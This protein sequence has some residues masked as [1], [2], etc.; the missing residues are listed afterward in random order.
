MANKIE[1][2]KS[3]I[4]QLSEKKYLFSKAFEYLSE[5]ILIIENNE[6]IVIINSAFFKLL[7]IEEK[8]SIMKLS[9]LKRHKILGD[10][11]RETEASD[12]IHYAREIEMFDPEKKV[13]AIKSLL[14]K[15][16][17]LNEYRIFILQDVTLLR[18]LRNEPFEKRYRKAM[19]SLGAGLAHEIGNPLNAMNIHIQLIKMM[20][21]KNIFNEDDI[22]NLKNEV[23]ILEEEIKRIDGVIS[24]FLQAV[25]PGKIMYKEVDIIDVIK[26]SVESFILVANKKNIKIDF[27]F[28]FERKFIFADGEKISQAI[29]NI[30]KNAIEAICSNG[31]IRISCYEK[32]GYIYIE[33]MD[34]GPGI[35][36]EKISSIFNPFFTTKTNGMGL[37]LVIAHQAVKE[38]DGEI[39]VKSSPGKGTT[40]ILEI[41]LREFKLK[42]IESKI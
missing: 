17:F 25:R 35:D 24:R 22:N 27:K 16:E 3:L 39:I 30:V 33:I 10:I 42:S 6:N 26:K 8:N 38:H 40:F 20:L 29:R 14:I 37:G 31:N 34:D 5:G 28:D 9:D 1:D 13:L 21:K 19:Y 12:F 15:D 36:K 7:N 32:D 23:K 2:L 18:K 4:K 11:I 41:P